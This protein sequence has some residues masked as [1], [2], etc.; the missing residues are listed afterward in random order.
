[1]E[2]IIQRG[3]TVC[4]E[5]PAFDAKNKKHNVLICLQLW[6]FIKYYR[7]KIF[8]NQLTDTLKIEMNNFQ[9]KNDNEIEVIYFFIL[10]R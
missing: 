9:N 10:F 8:K 1:M 2:S 7:E 6:H 3:Y 4:Y 5:L